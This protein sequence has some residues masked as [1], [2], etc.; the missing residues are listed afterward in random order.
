M[1]VPCKYDETQYSFT[2]RTSLW[3]VPASIHSFLCLLTSHS[4]Y[5]AIQLSHNT[6]FHKWQRELFKDRCNMFIL[7]V[8]LSVTYPI[9]QTPVSLLQSSGLWSRVPSHHYT[10]SQPRWWWTESSWPWKPQ[11]SGPYHWFNSKCYQTNIIPIQIR[12]ITKFIL[13]IFVACGNEK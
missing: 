6:F 2:S 8:I 5:Y 11:I 13:H 3:P 12:A 10:T 4:V 1:K 9:F 7:N